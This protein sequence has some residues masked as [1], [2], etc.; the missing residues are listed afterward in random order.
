MELLKDIQRVFDANGITDSPVQLLILAEIKATQEL[1]MV[2]AS[3]SDEQ[4]AA[5]EQTLV[6]LQAA[7]LLGGMENLYGAHCRE[8][9]QRFLADRKQ[10]GT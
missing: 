7:Q 1:M 4:F 9:L 8:Q 2:T 6:Q 5:L 3:S 10:G